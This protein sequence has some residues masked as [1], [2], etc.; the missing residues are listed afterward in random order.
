MASR[1]RPDAIC[2]ST[3]IGCDTRRLG[4]SPAVPAARGPSS[5]PP[6]GRGRR[7]PVI[8]SRAVRAF[9]QKRRIL[10]KPVKTRARPLFCK[11]H[12][13]FG[14]F[15]VS[16]VSVAFAVFHSWE[17]V[18]AS[19]FTNLHKFLLRFA[20]AHSCPLRRGEAVWPCFPTQGA[21]SREDEAKGM[22]RG[23]ACQTSSQSSDPGQTLKVPTSIL[24]VSRGRQGM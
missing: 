8:C 10:R 24:W 20:L 6:G 12:F 21:E 16:A 22:V 3:L 9:L 13:F 19:Q 23:T 5:D 15:S 2:P 18:F 1:E 7:A 17:D 14:F 11:K 4:G